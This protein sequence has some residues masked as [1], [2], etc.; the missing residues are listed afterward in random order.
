VIAVAK[1]VYGKEING[2]RAHS[3]LRF[4]AADQALLDELSR[5]ELGAAQAEA[6]SRMTSVPTKHI[7]RVSVLGGRR[8]LINAVW[9]RN[10]SFVVAPLEQGLYLHGRRL[11]ELLVSVQDVVGYVR[12]VHLYTGAQVVV[13]GA[14]GQ[15]RTSL[16]A[17][18]HV[19]LP[20]SGHVTIAGARYLVGSFSLQGWGGE[21]LTVSVLEPA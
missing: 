15:A 8:T 6:Y 14:S 5:G 13:R 21:P 19:V 18:G 7:T 12:L 1:H 4:I 9:N 11:G 16:A 17:A 10:G 3:D 20:G 2:G